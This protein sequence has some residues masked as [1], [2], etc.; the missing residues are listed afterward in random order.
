MGEHSGKK[1]SDLYLHV[2]LLYVIKTKGNT[3]EKCTY[4]LSEQS[5][6]FDEKFFF[7]RMSVCLYVCQFRSRGH[8]F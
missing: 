8:S 7:R 4:W 6:R 3:I 2:F 1:M 5:L